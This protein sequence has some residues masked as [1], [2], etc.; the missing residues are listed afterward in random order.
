MIALILM[1]TQKVIFS[2]TIFAL[3]LVASS[4]EFCPQAILATG[5]CSGSY[6][7]NVIKM[8]IAPRNSEEHCNLVWHYIE[9]DY[10][11]GL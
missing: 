11:T 6:P 2:S 1:Q 3:R 4:A 9:V 8:N 5:N 7:G 10:A